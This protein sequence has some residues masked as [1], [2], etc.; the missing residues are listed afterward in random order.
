MSNP[1]R[2]TQPNWK[3]KFTGWMFR[4]T[5][6]IVRGFIILALFLLAG[7]AL[8][9]LIFSLASL[10]DKDMPWLP[11]LHVA[12][13][14]A[15]FSALC[16]LAIVLVI[17][18]GFI[19]IWLFLP[20]LIRP[21]PSW[22]ELARSIVLTGGLLFCWAYHYNGW[23]FILPLEQI[24]EH[25]RK[26]VNSLRGG[27]F[28]DVAT[29]L[30]VDQLLVG[31]GLLAFAEAFLT[32]IVVMLVLR[33]LQ[34]FALGLRLYAKMAHRVSEYLTKLFATIGKI[35]TVRASPP[36]PNEPRKA[37]KSPGRSM[38]LILACFIG[39]V[40]MI[41]IALM[42][43]NL[44]ALG[45]VVGALALIVIMLAAVRRGSQEVLR[46]DALDNALYPIGA[47]T[48]GAVLCFFINPESS[49][50]PLFVAW[51][52]ERSWLLRFVVRDLAMGIVIVVIMLWFLCDSRNS[53]TENAV[54]TASGEGN[55][56]AAGEKRLKRRIWNSMWLFFVFRAAT[57][58]VAW[59]IAFVSSDRIWPT[60]PGDGNTA[61]AI[62]VPKVNFDRF[63]YMAWTGDVLQADEYLYVASYVK[64]PKLFKNDG[65]INTQHRSKFLHE[66]EKVRPYYSVFYAAL[67]LI[68][69]V[70]GW[71]YGITL[72]SYMLFAYA[73][74]LFQDPPPPA[75]EALVEDYAARR[76]AAGVIARLREAIEAIT[77]LGFIGT[78]LGLSQAIFFLGVSDEVNDFLG[79]SGISSRLSGSLGLAF[80]TTF[81]AMVLRLIINMRFS[82]LAAQDRGYQ[83]LFKRLSK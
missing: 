33:L 63:V 35:A 37:G 19:L 47:L 38:L 80:F 4:M 67:V 71:N 40:I 2:E 36:D 56:E 74:L 17:F 69:A 77:T 59:L 43:E 5:Q 11:V 12:N 13:L 1:S 75:S 15:F 42:G 54:D 72:L 53:F 78:L 7:A 68:Q 10:V 41:V 79:K 20:I 21:E 44:T 62:I 30:T 23:D 76:D 8:G 16:L 39:N 45:L 65:Q 34:L 57:I 55:S 27:S 48:L 70:F 25:I 82:Q 66:A 64:N 31:T 60:K 52:N 26:S 24:E 22:E 61:D 58:V 3:S 73:I 14:Y 49:G 18:I 6:G 83:T 51:G 50:N 29:W 46:E 28:K 9:H 32:Y 81:V